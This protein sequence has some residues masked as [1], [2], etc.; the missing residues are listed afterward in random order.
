MTRSKITVIGAGN[1]GATLAVY[2]ARQELGQ[3]VLMDIAEGLPQGKAIDLNQSAGLRGY[4]PV[5][6]GTNDPAEMKDSQIVAITAG[7]AR[8]PGMERIELLK[9]N[10][11]VIKGI[12]GNIKTYCPEAVILMVTNPVDVMALYALKISGFPANRVIGQ[13]GVLDSAR[14]A[15][16]IAEELK[17]PLADVEALV[18]GGHD[19]TM[20]PLARYS[21]V[22]GQT[23]DKIL[24]KEKLDELAEKTRKGGEQIVNFLKTGSA[25]YAPAAATAKMIEAMIKNADRILPTTCYLNGQYGLNDVYLGLPARLGP[26]GLR[27]IVNLQLTQEEIDVLINSA[28]TYQESLA[29]ILN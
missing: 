25:F 24:P 29:Q 27:E 15:Y 18:I 4:P 14:Y 28:K 3:I 5:I 11:E 16:F 13:G 10:A 19:L 9:K 22:K 23:L 1:V 20:L 2:L 8:K 17:V 7:F 26:G 6:T 21:K 12:V